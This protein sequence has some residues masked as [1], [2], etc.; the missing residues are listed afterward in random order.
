MHWGAAKLEYPLR[1]SEEDAAMTLVVRKPQIERES[2]DLNWSPVPEFAHILNGA[3]VV[4]P[5]VEHYLNNVMN[6]V[7]LHHC[8]DYPDLDQ[9]IA[10]FIKQEAAHSRYHMTFNKLMFD[11]GYEDLKE[12]I[13]KTVADLQVLRKNRS[14]AFNVAYCAGFETVATFSAKYTLED[15]DA[16]FSGGD[17]YGA[18]LILWHLAEEF[19][20]RTTCHRALEAVGGGYI[21]RILGFGYSFWHINLLFTRAAKI[22]LAKYR[23]DMTPA[24]H[25]RSRRIVRQ[26]KRRQLFHMLPGLARLVLPGYDPAKI[27]IT[28]RIAETL[29]FFAKAG[30]LTAVFSDTKRELPEAA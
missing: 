9:E 11:S 13:G 4:I 7:R 29:A 27:K 15:C 2:P 1:R 6:E 3:S 14:L 26:L 18:N 25:R 5:Y 20:H 10:L 12:V 24:E 8:K 19:E 30:P 16:M 22:I 17:P 28:P 21:M 23:S